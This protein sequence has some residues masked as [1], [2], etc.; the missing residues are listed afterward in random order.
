MTTIFIPVEVPDGELGDLLARFASA[1][2]GATYVGPATT[3]S[4][5]P[6]TQTPQPAEQPAYQQQSDPWETATPAVQTGQPQYQQPRTA[7]AS[8]GTMPSGQPPNC[9]HGQMQPIAA[10]V[11]QAGKPYGPGWSCPAPRGQQC[12]P[13]W[14]R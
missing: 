11:S 14:R 13:V 5:P 4:N 7:P 10:G 1:Q 6:S 9:A 8:P 3:Q 12:K 2:M